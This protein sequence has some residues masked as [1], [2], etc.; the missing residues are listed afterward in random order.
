M[1]HLNVDRV[2]AVCAWCQTYP[3]VH[4]KKRFLL[5]VFLLLFFLPPLLLFCFVVF[6]TGF[7]YVALAVLELAL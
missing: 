7:L 4:V 3:S 1:I 2:S 6:E 5:P